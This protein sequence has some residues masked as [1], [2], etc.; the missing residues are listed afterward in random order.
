MHAATEMRSNLTTS[1]PTQEASVHQ[2]VSVWSVGHGA[3]PG[4]G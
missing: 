1:Q 4:G 3:S 2:R